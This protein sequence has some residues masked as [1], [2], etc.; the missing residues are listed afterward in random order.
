MYVDNFDTD[1]FFLCRDAI[2]IHDTLCEVAMR[3][4]MMQYSTLS[5]GNTDPFSSAI[6]H[7]PPFQFMCLYRLN[8]IRS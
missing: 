6:M 3:R 8:N 2:P 4:Q 5:V 7:P 1:A